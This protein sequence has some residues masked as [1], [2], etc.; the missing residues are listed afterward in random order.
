M[1][2]LINTQTPNGPIVSD[3]A[4]KLSDGSFV[5]R[6]LNEEYLKWVVE[7]NTPEPA[8]E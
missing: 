8:D 5:H 4:L 7:G 6:E 1:Y 2:K 3:Y